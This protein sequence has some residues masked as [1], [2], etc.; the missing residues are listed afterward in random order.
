MLPEMRERE[1][2]CKFSNCTHRSEPDCAIK[3]AVERKIAASRYESYVRL[4]EEKRRYRR[5][6]RRR[7]RTKRA[8]RALIRPS[9]PSPASQ[10]KARRYNGF[11][12]SDKDSRSSG[13]AS[14]TKTT[15]L[16]S[17]AFQ[18]QSFCEAGEGGR[19]PDE[20]ILTKT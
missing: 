14:A 8:L 18:P 11:Q 9:P 6:I 10:E 17:I 1:S 13:I 16:L 20:G 4:F 5:N 12:S 15:Q 19:R 7:M 3:S 2:K